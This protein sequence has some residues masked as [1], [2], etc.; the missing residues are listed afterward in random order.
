MFKEFI[1]TTLIIILKKMTTMI[2]KRF[3]IRKSEGRTSIRSH[4]VR[5]LHT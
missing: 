2:R 4:R 5:S 1:I 3:E